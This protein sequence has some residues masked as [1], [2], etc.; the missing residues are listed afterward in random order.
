MN[1]DLTDEQKKVRDMA[2]N[3]TTKVIA[4]RAKEMDRTGEYPYDIMAQM[5]SL[6]MMGIPFPKEYGGGGGDWVSMHLCIEEISRGDVSLGALLDV[7]TS[8]AGNEIYS[9]GTEEQKQKWL[10]PLAQGK[11]I[12]AFGL[13]EPDAGSDTAAL[14]TTAALEGEEWVINGS[15]QF[16]T[17]TGLDNASIIIITAKTRV[18]Q[19][20]RTTIST[21]IVPKGTPGFTLG[22]RYEKMAF[23]A[24]ATHEVF[25]DDCRIPK[26]YLLGDIY[27]GL[28]QHLSVLQ[29]GRISV[30]A[31]STGLAQACLDEALTYTTKKY[32]FR[33]SL[34]ESQTIPFKLADIAMMIELSR[35]I[36]LKAAWLKDQGRDYTLEAH[37]AKLFATETAKKI[38]SDVLNMYGLFG[39]L[40]KYPISR[41][42]KVAKLFE[43]VEGT[44]EMQRLVIAR[45]L[46]G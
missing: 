4:P 15:K 14:K 11:E 21:L 29:T 40:E 5:A 9:F 13:T 1:F 19:S 26:G 18:E 12:G 30:A 39:C 2:R 17:N 7:T 28:A 35:T 36:Y 34:L 27:E 31:I 44:S 16:I 42:F 23:H 45:K 32:Q 33:Q 24:S 10:I 25:F 3:F 6:G 41:Y 37:F 46:L 38:A 43:I 22:E 8:V 20:G